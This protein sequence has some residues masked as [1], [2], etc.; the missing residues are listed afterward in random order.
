MKE[1]KVLVGDHVAAKYNIGEIF[2][3]QMQDSIV[4][5]K[6]DARWPGCTYLFIK[7]ETKQN[8]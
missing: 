8:G 6:T 2:R 4:I 3:F 5:G 7:I 1:L